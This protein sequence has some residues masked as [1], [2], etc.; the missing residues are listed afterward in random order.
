MRILILISFLIP[1][2]VYKNTSELENVA[3]D[4]LL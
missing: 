1:L 4:Y 2:T 3:Y